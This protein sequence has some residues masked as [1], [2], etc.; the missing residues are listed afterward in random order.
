MTSAKILGFG[1]PH[2]LS[3]HLGLLGLSDKI[4]ATYHTTFFWSP[5][6]Q[7]EHCERHLWLV[8]DSSPSPALSLV[9]IWFVL[10]ISPI[11][12]SFWHTAALTISTEAWNKE[13]SNLDDR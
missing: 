9:Q 12:E 4:D 10:H 2:L 8:P 7:C 13:E 3:L 5:P 11:S 6:S 1:L